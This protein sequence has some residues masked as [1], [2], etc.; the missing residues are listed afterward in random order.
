MGDEL[1][2]LA[3]DDGPQEPSP[4]DNMSKEDLLSAISKEVDK[5]NTVPQ[6]GSEPQPAV[7]PPAAPAGQPSDK[8][9]QPAQPTQGTPAPGEPQAPTQQPVAPVEAQ[10]QTPELQELLKK[11][12][13]KS[14]NELAK[15]YLDLE[16]QM[17]KQ[18]GELAKIGRQGVTP[19]GTEG[20]PAQIPVE[21]QQGLQDADKEVF[22]RAL[23]ENPYATLKAL[24]NVFNQDIL[25]QQNEQA[26]HSTVVDLSTNPNTAEFNLPEV[27]E[28]MKVVITE[29]PDLAKNLKENLPDIFD[30]AVSRMYRAGKLSTKAVEAGKQI[31]EQNLAQRQAAVVEGAGVKPPSSPQPTSP[32]NMSKEDLWATIQKI[33]SGGR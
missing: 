30:K 16:K 14:P 7:Q 12:G 20:Q 29:R 5:V 3:P 23:Q 18:A 28:E 31:A 6:P 19:P 4:N 17:H 21:P 32:E 11:K 25:K 8:G 26:L 15:V 24:N 1:R 33:A 27:Q 2:Q 22:F 13:M 10:A 9:Q